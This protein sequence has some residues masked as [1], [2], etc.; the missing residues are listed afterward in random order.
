M[1]S[2]ST[3]RES[4]SATTLAY[5]EIP[6]RW[7]IAAR[8]TWIGLA[9]AN[10]LIVAASTRPRLALLRRVSADQSTR[11]GELRPEDAVALRRLGLS[12]DFYACYF[13][14]LEVAGALAFIG[15][16]LLLFWR[17]SRARIIW[18]ASLALLHFGAVISPLFETLAVVQ[19]G[20]QTPVVLIRTMA[21]AV[22]VVFL[23]VF[24]DGRFVPAWMRWTALI[25]LGYVVLALFV[26]AL[27][28]PS[29]IV[30]ETPADAI[31]TLWALLWLSLGGLVQLYRYRRAAGPVVALPLVL[32]PTVRETGPLHVQYEILAFTLILVAQLVFAAAVAVATLRYRLYDIDIVINRTLVYAVLTGTLVLVYLVSVVLLQRLLPAESPLAIVISTLA[33]AALF[34]PLRRR[35]QNDIDRL[36][37]R[38]KYDAQQVLTE[39]AQTARDE[40]DLDR[41]TDEL[42][43]VVTETMRPAHVSVWLKPTQPPVPG[44]DR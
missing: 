23:F 18:F 26:P 41:L 31:R 27:R 40:T 10:L 35:I 11:L 21:L 15:I 25:W 2:R 33:I 37:Y 9:A 29:T 38:H 1:E 32:A 19:P 39:F 44:A 12:V 16:A 43:A 30:V 5:A 7:L 36:F 4:T 13:T 3:I 8:L 20:W 28:A 42:T 24:P 34:N 6:S 22:I 17:G 14:V